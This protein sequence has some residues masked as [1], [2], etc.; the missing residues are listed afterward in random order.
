M[1]DAARYVNHRG[2]SVNLNGD[3][4][5]IKMGET[6]DWEVSHKELNGKISSFRN[7]Q[8]TIPL[9]VSEVCDTEDEGFRKRDELFEVASADIEA[10]KPGKLWIGDWYIAGYMV[11]SSKAAHWHTGRIAEY[12]IEFLTDAPLWTREHVS[13]FWAPNKGSTGSLDYPHNYPYNYRARTVYN[14]VLENPGIALAPI[15]LVFFGPVD[16]PRATINGNSYEVAAPLAAGDLLVVDGMD[17]TATL[18]R[19]GGGVENVFG[20]RVGIQKEGSG[21]Y[22]FQRIPPGLSSVNWSGKFGF[23]ATVYEQRMERRW[24]T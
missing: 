14:R 13:S 16:V 15:R 10:L 21:S 8:R 6:A 3:G 5:Y 1:K 9:I 19:N 17:K 18:V 24:S 20:K 7:G 23:D 2:V 12:S 11:S 4:L 22:L